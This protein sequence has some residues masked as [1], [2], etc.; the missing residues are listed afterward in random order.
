MKAYPHLGRWLAASVTAAVFAAIALIGGFAD[1]SRS[2][3][4]AGNDVRAGVDSWPMYGGTHDR[5]MVNLHAKGLP[6]KWDAEEKQNIL[7]SADL[8]SKAYGG[9]VVSGGKILIGTNNQRPRDPK[10]RDADGKPIDKGVLMS[11]DAAKGDFL[12]QITF[13]KLAAGRVNDW[14]EEGLCSTPVI[15]GDKL[16]FVNNRCE[17]VCAKTDGKIAWKLDMI[18]DLGVFPHNI[19]ACSP[20]LV[21]D[22]LFIV[23][24]NGV[25]E[26][27]INVPAPQAPS[28][29][30]LDKADGKVIW[31]NNTPSA[32]LLDAPKE[33]DQESFF[34]RLVNRGELLQHGQW[35]N[36]AYGVVNGQPQVIFPGGDG[37]LYALEP[38]TGKLIWKFDCNPKDAFYVLGSRGT[39]SDFIATPV[40]YDNKAYIG[41]GQDPEHEVGVGHL[42]CIDMTK[43][44]D[45]SPQ[46]VTD[47]SVFPP[48]TKANPNS[49]MVWH[50]GGPADAKKL[51]RN[52]YFGRTMS[53]C[54]I[55]DGLVYAAE[56]GGYLHC[57]DARTGAV[58]WVHDL[59]GKTWSSPYWAD[60]KIYLGTDSEKVFVFA[61]GK[62]KKLLAENDM[63]SRV[64]ATPVAANG[65]LYVMT[66]N[67]LFAIGEKK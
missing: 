52:Y 44:G 7:W 9:P 37:W 43:K 53:T 1:R 50:Y 2:A 20:L 56:L 62:Q 51:G 33:G 8:G 17:V 22:R 65:V 14:P 35:S 24:A 32:K 41:T 21:G 34:K 23:T 40:I 13:G 26:G 15:E 6:T 4:N 19:A 3:A 47:A 42:W 11:F 57:L 45:V 63:A 38:D 36:P 12:W 28:W 5:N 30:C 39:R 16:Y 29:L 54:A 10:D 64:R 48:K 46:L 27:H 25:D 60:G 49:A 66:E 18:K 58:Y 55:H 67:K 61:H 59:S 31:K